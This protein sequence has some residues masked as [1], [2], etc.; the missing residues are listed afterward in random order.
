MATKAKTETN[1]A[2]AA[3]DSMAAVGNEAVKE[4]MDK[5]MKSFGDF[6]TFG[7]DTIEA[8]MTSANAVTKNIE[9]MNSEAVTFSKQTLEEGMS[10]AKAA[11][12][13]RSLQE[14]IEIN[15]DY[16]KSAFDAY[17]GQL[18]KVSDMMVAAAKATTEPLND[19]F[20]AMVEMVQSYRP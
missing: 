20:S 7:R 2:T 1:G 13:S 5:M 6:S 19:R 18:N 12:T 17:M 9:T 11:M 3:L 10:A 4:S 8:F 16:T 15:T 14:L